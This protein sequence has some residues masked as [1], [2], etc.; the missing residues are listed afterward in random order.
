MRRLL[1]LF[2]IFL[3]VEMITFARD[4]FGVSEDKSVEEAHEGEVLQGVARVLDQVPLST[5]HTFS[6]NLRRNGDEQIH[7]L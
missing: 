1:L 3:M 2:F 7:D 5:F 4:L 6:I